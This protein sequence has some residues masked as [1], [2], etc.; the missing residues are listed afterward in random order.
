MTLTITPDRGRIGPFWWFNGNMNPHHRQLLRPG[1]ALIQWGTCG[2][3]RH[4]R[5]AYDV[6]E[7]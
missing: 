5:I 7:A 6:V 2:W 1:Y 3:G 4:V